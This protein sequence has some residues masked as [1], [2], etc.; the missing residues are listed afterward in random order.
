[1]RSKRVAPVLRAFAAKILRLGELGTGP[2]AKALGAA[3]GALSI[4]IHTEM[5]IVA[6]MAGLDPAGVLDAL[7][8]LAPGMGTDRPPPW[9]RKCSPDAIESNVSSKRLQDDIGRVLDAARARPRLRHCSFRCCRPP[10]VGAGHSPR[11]TGSSLDVAR[12][13]TDNAGVEFVAAAPPASAGKTSK[14]HGNRER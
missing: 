13:M 14:S 2:L 6:K 4:A 8:L 1:M 11:A 12:W 9:A 7:P 3:F 10:S 5:L